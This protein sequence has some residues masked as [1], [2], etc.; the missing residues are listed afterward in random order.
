[1]GKLIKNCFVVDTPRLYFSS[2]KLEKS[3]ATKY[4]QLQL[5][6]PAITS[7]SCRTHPFSKWGSNCSLCRLYTHIIALRAYNFVF[8]LPQIS[9]CIC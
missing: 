8:T 1:M 5:V 7:C 3:M 2:T 6:C 4:A 9:I